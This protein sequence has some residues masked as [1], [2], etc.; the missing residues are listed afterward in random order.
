VK[1]HF[2]AVAELNAPPTSVNYIPYVDPYN[3]NAQSLYD[4]LSSSGLLQVFSDAAVDTGSGIRHYIATL[5][6]WPSGYPK[7]I[8]AW[9][10]SWL[11]N[12]STCIELQWGEADGWS[13]PDGRPYNTRPFLEFI[14]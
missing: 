2:F 9:T 7:S 6:V 4:S 14:P 11:A 12:E 5:P 13:P 3:Q 8:Q 1:L 10:F